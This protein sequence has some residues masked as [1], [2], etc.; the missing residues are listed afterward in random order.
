[1]ASLISPKLFSPLSAEEVVVRVNL[2]GLRLGIY[3]LEGGLS[4]FPPKSEFRS[5]SRGVGLS[6]EMRWK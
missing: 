4:D 1:M 6:P 5:H 2:S 3:T